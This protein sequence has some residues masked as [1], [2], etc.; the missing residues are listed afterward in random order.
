MNMINS[1]ITVGSGPLGILRA[2]L[3]LN[4]NILLRLGTD[5]DIVLVLNSAGL[6]ANE[7]LTNVI[8]G[9]SVYAVAIPANSLI[10][11][12]ITADGDIVFFTNT[13]GNSIEA[14][15]IDASN[16]QVLFPVLNDPVT[17]TIG[18][19]NGGFGFYAIADDIIGVSIAGV[20]R[21][22]WA[23]SAFNG[24]VSSPTVSIRNETATGTN[25][26]YAFTNDLD[27][28]GGSNGADQYSLIAGAHEMLRLTESIAVANYVAALF[29]AAD[30]VSL[31]SANSSTWRLIE[32]KDVNVDWDGGVLITALDGQS[33]YLGQITNTADQGTVVSRASSLYLKGAPVAGS[34]ITQTESWTVYVAS[35]GVA[36]V[37][38]RLLESQGADVGSTNNLVLG[39]DGNTFEITGTT[40]INL[41]SNLGWQNGAKVT[42]MF[43]STATVKDAQA[44]STTNI[45]ILLDGSAD[46]VPSAGDTLTLRLGE[47]GGT[48]AWREIGRS[49][50]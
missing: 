1:Q 7:E 38:G 44:T 3:T 17:P 16:Q 30:Q 19:G 40:D 13:G 18:F 34:N 42:L 39:T 10:V 6:S 25:P 46:F 21:F 33:L 48:Q 12:N 29:D 23:G 27:T 24:A 37:S 41:L 2:N 28:G 14:M 9:T 20:N 4:D 47:I 49:V 8:V 26:V 36:I 43:T 45:T 35:G 32:T 5:G 31:T 11:S 50:L 22:I 15:R